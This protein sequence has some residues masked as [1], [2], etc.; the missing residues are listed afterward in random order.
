MS[1]GSSSGSGADRHLLALLRAIRLRQAA[2]DAVAAGAADAAAA[3]TRPDETPDGHEPLLRPGW[4]SGE[5]S[6]PVR[7][8]RP[9]G[10]TPVAPGRV[11]AVDGMDASDEALLRQTQ[12]L[13]R[14]SLD[15]AG[16]AEAV[17]GRLRTALLE[18]D[19]ALVVALPGAPEVQTRKLTEGLIWLVD[20][21]D[22][23][24]LLVS[25]AERLGAALAACG[26]PPDGLQ[27]VGAALAEA[28]RAG[29]PA[30][31]WRQEFE[32]AWRSTW[33]HVYEWMRE[34][35]DDEPVAWT[36]VVVSHELRRPDLAVIRLR[37]YL[38]MPFRPGQ[39]SRIEVSRVPGVWRPYSLAGAPRR[40]DLVEL[41]VRAKTETGVSGTLVHHT[42]VGDEVRIGRA[43][44]DM[45]LHVRPDRDLLMIAGDTGVAPLK[46]LLTELAD[47]G[48]SR[49]AVVFWGVRNLAELYDI[50]EI[51]EIARAAKRA[52]VVPVVSEGDPGPYAS[53]LVTDAVAA[54]GE[55]SQHEVY[56]AG[57]PLMLAATSAAL[58]LLGVQPDHIHH[59]APE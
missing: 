38:P 52:T 20:H 42:V 24:P 30:G 31:E 55:W 44:G 15:F 34:T 51:A 12:S 1:S 43:E 41:H 50:A 28:M 2:P 26:V 58:H 13:L 37:P 54:Y 56:L 25:G 10:M 16:G 45:G 9:E 53:G 33:Q 3:L 32:V 6:V 7:Q 29:S 49:S 18:A 17:A 39:Y 14:E 59:D 19:P 57:P 46:A 40:D 5:R 36:A 48:D 35:A 27:F 22:Q 47:T 4:A 23:P 21:L 11:P 8:P